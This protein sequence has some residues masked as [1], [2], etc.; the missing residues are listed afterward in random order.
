[1]QAMGGIWG[2]LDKGVPYSPLNLLS[3]HQKGIRRGLWEGSF[4]KKFLVPL[5]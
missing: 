2:N 5:P 4:T 1:M 3:H